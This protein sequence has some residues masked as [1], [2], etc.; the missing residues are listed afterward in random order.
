MRRRRLFL[1]SRDLRLARE[2]LILGVPS[3]VCS[4]RA[5]LSFG[6]T[7]SASV[8]SWDS[9]SFEEKKFQCKPFWVKT[10]SG[11][12]LNL[13]RG[14]NMAFLQHVYNHNCWKTESLTT[15]VELLHVHV[16]KPFIQ[17]FLWIFSCPITHSVMNLGQSLVV[18]F[19]NLQIFQYV[20]LFPLLI[21]FPEVWRWTSGV[22]RGHRHS[23]LLTPCQG[24]CVP[25][26]W[27]GRCLQTT[28]V[29]A[30]STTYRQHLGKQVIK[31]M[32]H[33][34]YY[35]RRWMTTVVCKVHQIGRC[36]LSLIS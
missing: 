11:V 14:N 30:F 10:E 22:C 24:H 19:K 31:L 1:L 17:K 29:T 5:R 27:N 25:A 3:L 28:T 7:D 9:G 32:M 13:C 33:I 20:H 34:C 36:M 18:F 4:W 2:D 8:S 12:L 26:V 35:K 15:W 21:C 23:E 16:C 6:K